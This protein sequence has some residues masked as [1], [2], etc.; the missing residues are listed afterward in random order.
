MTE[1]DR[2]HQ[3]RHRMP[4]YCAMRRVSAHSLSQIGV[5][6]LISRLYLLELT[7]SGTSHAPTLSQIG[8][9]FV[10]ALGFDENQINPAWLDEIERHLA[11][12]E[13]AAGPRALV[14]SASGKFWSNGLDLG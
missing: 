14:T 6:D 11:T 12:A 5:D 13:G 4:T 8:N 3:A 7:F 1:S 10:L 2:F 9:A